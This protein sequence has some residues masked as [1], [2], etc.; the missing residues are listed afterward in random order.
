MGYLDYYCYAPE[1]AIDWPHC[2]IST[3]SP[4]P[5]G[6]ADRGVPLEFVFFRTV[7]DQEYEGSF[8]IDSVIFAKT[9]H[10]IPTI[11]TL[12]PLMLFEPQRVLGLK[13]QW[14]LQE[15]A[16][17]VSHFPERIERPTEQ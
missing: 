2:V 4:I 13:I 9:V 3:F 1:R 10:F 11:P 7:G 12:S 16:H 6:N 15:T 17:A 14:L 5:T 8:L